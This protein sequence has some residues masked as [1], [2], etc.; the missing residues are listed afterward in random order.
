[1]K[2]NEQCL[3]EGGNAGE[4]VGAVP[5]ENIT[6]GISF[7]KYTSKTLLTKM[8][9]IDSDYRVKKKSAAMMF[10]GKYETVEVKTLEEF[11]AVLDDLEYEQAAGYGL[12]PADSGSICVKKR[13]GVK[14]A[15]A[16]S[17]KNFKFG[18]GAGIF[19]LDIDPRKDGVTHTAAEIHKMLVDAVPE[20]NGVRMLCRPSASS[21]IYAKCDFPDGNIKEDEVLIPEGGWHL[22]FFLDRACDVPAIG[23]IVN[24]KLWLAE[25][26]Y[27][28]ITGNGVQLERNLVDTCVWQGERLDFAAGAKCISDFVAKRDCNPQY[29]GTGGMLVAANVVQLSPDEERACAELVG[30]EM[31]RTAGKAKKIRKQWLSARVDGMVGKDA[32]KKKRKACRKSLVKMMEGGELP[33]D[34]VLY[35]DKDKP[36]TLKEMLANSDKYDGMTIC[37][38]VEP[39]YRNGNWDQNTNVD[40]KREIPELCS[41]SHGVKSIYTFA[42]PKALTIDE[43]CAQL[44]QLSPLE[45]EKDRKKYATELGVTSKTLM[46]EVKRLRDGDDGGAATQADE[47]IALAQDVGAT[48]FHD[49]KDSSFAYVSVD[50]HMEV[51]CCSNQEFRDWLHKIYWEATNRTLRSASLKESV[52]ALK[53]LAKLKGKLN[54]VF[55]RVGIHDGKYYIDLGDPEWRVIELSPNGWQILD[56][57]PIKFQRSGLSMALP[58]PV[59][60]SGDLNSLWDVINVRKEHRL[61]V[62]TWIIE[63]LR[64]N[65]PFPV[66]ELSGEQGSAKS[67]IQTVLR[68]LIDP[69]RVNLRGAPRTREDIDAQAKASHLLSYENLSKIS[70]PIQDALCT[71]STGGGDAK[72]KLYSDNDEAVVELNNPVI[73]NGIHPVITAGDLA[74]RAIRLDLPVIPDAQRIPPEVINRKFEAAMPAIFTAILDAFVGALAVIES[75]SLQ[76]APRMMDFALMGEALNLHLAFGKNF[77]D[78]YR[79]MRASLL[80]EAAQGS[81][82][83]LAITEL[84]AQG[85][86]YQGTYKELL[87]RLEDY[88]PSVTGG[89]WPKSP[90]GLAAQL[91][92][93]KPGLRAMGLKITSAGHSKSGNVIRIKG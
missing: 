6:T 42:E 50:G 34:Y 77:N 73:L 84:V 32:S 82:A 4:A 29:F 58:I 8:V 5:D 22:Y 11:N 43:R 79:A 80:I 26:G 47:L 14:G 2:P 40:L 49:G 60:G 38:P 56:E 20:L 25:R 70:A 67:F 61:F 78:D 90:R 48:L 74:D 91:T 87:L 52:D 1:M 17:K 86:P 62:L 10:E 23:K 19:M 44:A 24:K 31:A 76:E 57:S 64:S 66:C 72:R 89:E 83:M 3:H 54:Q 46:A 13:E 37:D 30:A 15:I 81:P 53:S 21:N 55:R 65:T 16:R 33:R 92:R 85:I 41:W 59:K 51:L 39:E 35:L 9:F 69:N 93:H 88:K 28:L 18:D 75:I 36:I 7:T 71:A 63:S 45:F 68:K 12:G 27:I